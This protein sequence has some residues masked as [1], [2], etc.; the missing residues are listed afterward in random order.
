MDSDES[1]FYGDEETVAGLETRVTSFNVAQWWKELNAVHINRRVKK[2]PLDSTKLHNPYAGVPYA[3]Q[4][5]ETV[6]DF[7]ARLPPGTTEHD[8]RLPWIFI[9]N[10]YIDRKVKSEAQNQRSRGNEDEAPEEEGSRLDTLIEGGIERLNILLKFKQGI[11]TTKKSMAA[12]MI[13]IG[14]EKKEAIQD[15]LGLAHASQGR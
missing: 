3:W 7:L 8:D 15:I 4:L 12:K 11:S 5:T 10:P 14:L 6:D 1:D 2:E 13:E 9:C